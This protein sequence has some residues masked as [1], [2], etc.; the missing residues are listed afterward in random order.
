MR[1]LRDS[2]YR[3]E[4]FF[5]DSDWT[6]SKL[7]VALICPKLVRG[8]GK[9]DAYRTFNQVAFLDSV[10]E[11]D[12]LQDVWNTRRGIIIANGGDKETRNRQMKLLESLDDEWIENKEVVYLNDA[13]SKLGSSCEHGGLYLP[14]GGC[15]FPSRLREAL[16]DDDDDR[17]VETKVESISRREDECIELS[18]EDGSKEIVD[19]VIVATGSESSKLLPNHVV[20]GS[21]LRTSHGM[22]CCCRSTTL[23]P[24]TSIL[25]ERGIG[26][27][28]V[29]AAAASDDTFLVGAAVSRNADEMWKVDALSKKVSS[30][31]RNVRIYYILS[32]IRERTHCF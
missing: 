29:T 9:D 22:V 10:R 8:G 30:I 13:S 28:Y 27:G 7:P 11:L 6:S 18:C 1:S 3:P 4:L 32:N 23:P 16:L 21:T 15:I 26:G 20:P 12:D 14:R 17:V 25:R 24:L 2:G 19:V 31:L 5:K